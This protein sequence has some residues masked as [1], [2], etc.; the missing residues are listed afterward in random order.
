MT[1]LSVRSTAVALTRAP[2][3]CSVDN[4]FQSANAAFATVSSKQGDERRGTSTGAGDDAGTAVFHD[5]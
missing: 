1:L 2:L 3:C 4:A 5:E